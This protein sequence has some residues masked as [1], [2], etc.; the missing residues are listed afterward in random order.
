MAPVS[1]LLVFHLLSQY[2]VMCRLYHISHR[3]YRVPSVSVRALWIFWHWNLTV[4]LLRLTSSLF[5]VVDRAGRPSLFHVGKAFASL[6]LS[7][8]YSFLCLVRQLVAIWRP[9][10]FL[11]ADSRREK[12]LWLRIRSNSKNIC[13]ASA[14]TPPNSKISKLAPPGF[15]RILNAI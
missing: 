5:W 14:P 10:G 11:C 12:S 7:S 13:S 4:G 3:H 8:G 1:L 9:G 6:R 15:R 2:L